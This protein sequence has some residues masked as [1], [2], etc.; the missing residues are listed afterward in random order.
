MPQFRCAPDPIDHRDR[1]LFRLG[2]MPRP[3]FRFRFLLYPRDKGN[4]HRRVRLHVSVTDTS[5]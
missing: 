5:N 4:V 1:Y 3:V 2:R